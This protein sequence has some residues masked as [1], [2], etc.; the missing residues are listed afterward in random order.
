MLAGAKLY[1]GESLPSV[2]V[3]ETWNDA[4]TALLESDAWNDVRFLAELL[5]QMDALRTRENI[6]ETGFAGLINQLRAWVNR[7]LAN[8]RSLA[9]NSSELLGPEVTRLQEEIR[10]ALEGAQPF[11][12]ATA[13]QIGQAKGSG[14]NSLAA[15]VTPAEESAAMAD[16]LKAWEDLSPEAQARLNRVADAQAQRVREQYEGT[17]GWMKAP[18]GQPTALDERQWVQVRTPLFKQ[19]FGDWEATAEIHALPRTSTANN[20][21]KSSVKKPLPH[22]LP[23]DSR[24]ESTTRLREESPRSGNTRKSSPTSQTREWTQ[25]LRQSSGSRPPL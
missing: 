11:T 23:T 15:S 24:Q 7:A 12:T 10:R 3:A 6:T 2:Q 14:L 25:T 9:K 20:A 13:R 16:A 8:L 17:E 21:T 4:K 22:R 19:W 1:F 18:N 5:R